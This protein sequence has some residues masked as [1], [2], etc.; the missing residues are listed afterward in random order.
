MVSELWVG[1][2]NRVNDL[3]VGSGHQINNPR[4]GSGHWVNNRRFGSGIQVKPGPVSDRDFLVAWSAVEPSAF[5][6]GLEDVQVDELG[7][8]AE[9]QCEVTASL[10]H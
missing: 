10:S 9:F 6:R 7:V 1:S 5:V 2:G 8:E 3:R 4:V